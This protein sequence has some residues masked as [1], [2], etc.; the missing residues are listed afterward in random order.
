MDEGLLPGHPKLISYYFPSIPSSITA[1]YT[2]K[3]GLTYFFKD[4]YFY[5][6]KKGTREVSTFLLY[7]D[8]LI[9]FYNFRTSYLIVI[10]ARCI[11]VRGDFI[12]KFISNIDLIAY[13][14]IVIRIENQYKWVWL[15]KNGCTCYPGMYVI[16]T[17]HG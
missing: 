6:L 11:P 1:V 3:H 10:P 12:N 2:N 17:L 8:M 5:R 16:L 4:N 7:N 14:L 9:I 15:L 13:G